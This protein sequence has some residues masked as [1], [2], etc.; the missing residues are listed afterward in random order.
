MLQW[1][2]Y[3]IDLV[4][5]RKDL[6]KLLKGLE[7]IQTGFA[8]FSAEKI[9]AANY[10]ACYQKLSAM[11]E[12][13]HLFYDKAVQSLR[14]KRA[15][16]DK[17]RDSQEAFW[18]NHPLNLTRFD[19]H[20][21]IDDVRFEVEKVKKEDKEEIKLTVIYDLNK[22]EQWLNSRFVH[23]AGDQDSKT[24]KAHIK[25]DSKNKSYAQREFEAA[26]QYLKGLIDSVEV[27]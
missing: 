26:K 19:L 21:V 13:P 23:E 1:F 5:Q 9:T 12:T 4:R 2:D 7:K 14:H 17:L 10:Q 11:A 20:A 27:R 18:Q 22:D 15:L 3:E 16:S 25:G 24:L 6:E 8:D